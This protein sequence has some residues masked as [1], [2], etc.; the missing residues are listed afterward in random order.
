MTGSVTPRLWTPPLR[1]LTPATSWGFDFNDFCR[2]VI[3]EPNDPWQEWLSIHVGEL[4]PDGR[5]RFRRVLIL[6]AR[7]QGKTSWA[8]KLILWWLFVD[9]APLVMATSS[10]R[11]YAKQLWKQVCGIARGN[12]LLS[13]ELGPKSERL[14]IGE[15][16][17]IRPARP[18]HNEPAAEYRFAASN[19]KAGRSATIHRALLDELREHDSFDT[20]NAVT[21]ATN[22]VR[23]AQLIAITNQGDDGAIVLDHLRLPAIKYLET[24]EGDHRTGLFEW[25]APDGADPTDL[26]ALAAANPDLGN[27]TDPDVLLADARSAVAAGGAELT[28]FRTEVMCQRVHVLN[29]AIDPDLWKQAATSTPTPLDQHRR[30]VALCVDVSLDGMHATLVAAAVLEGRVHVEIVTAWSGAGCTAQLRRDLPGIIAQVRPRVLGWWP[31]GPAA[32]VAADLADRGTRAWPPR[33][34]TVAEIKTEAAAACMGLAEQVTAG[35]LVHPDDP[36]LNLHVGAAV[37]LHTG[38]ARW[39]FTRNGDA[40]IDAAYAAAGAVHLA[41]TLPPAPPPL[42]AL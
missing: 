2:D 14:T 1:E 30:Q 25:S 33:G 31:T 39:T 3:G 37:K 35:E 29:P 32:S 28:G 6:V 12:P 19:R 24:G 22:A 26:A 7:Q 20:W 23:A 13:A 4:L 36:L 11:T 18:D 8:R 40:A 41:R 38:Q 27:R 15:E 34:V 42:V 5:P 17:L 16:A 21:Y 10:N 9:V